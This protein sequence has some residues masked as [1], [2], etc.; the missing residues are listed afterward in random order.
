MTVTPM[1]QRFIR[2]SA[3]GV[4][5]MFAI[6]A[7]P[8]VG[9]VGAGIDYSRAATVRTLPQATDRAR[10]NWGLETCR[11]SE[12]RSQVTLYKIASRSQR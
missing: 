11:T 8:L 12:N 2:N 4:A 7:I 6:A 10:R 3:G 5:P 1:L 9:A